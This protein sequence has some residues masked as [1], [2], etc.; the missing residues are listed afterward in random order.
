MELL[1]PVLLIKDV[2]LVIDH[3]LDVL[4]RSSYAEHVQELVVVQRSYYYIGV[5][6]DI[7]LNIEIIILDKCMLASIN[8][9]AIPQGAF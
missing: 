7:P 3:C 9:T 2:Q 8:T 4:I 5:I 6:L 1:N